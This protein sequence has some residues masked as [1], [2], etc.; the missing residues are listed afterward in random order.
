[1]GYTVID[2]IDFFGTPR[3][4][5]PFDEGDGPFVSEP[6]KSDVKYDIP[7]QADSNLV[8][9]KESDQTE[10]VEAARRLVS[11]GTA[12]ANDI[13]PTRSFRRRQRQSTTV[14]SPSRRPRR[15]P[16]R[17]CRVMPRSAAGWAPTRAW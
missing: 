16:D 4:D 1:M 8:E 3:L 15:Y 6:A 13:I 10:L 14:C 9:Q 17:P 12:Y 7:A 11:A 2:G 5:L